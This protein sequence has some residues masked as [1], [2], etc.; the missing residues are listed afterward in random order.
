[1]DFIYSDDPDSKVKTMSGDFISYYPTQR[2]EVSVS[3]PSATVSDSLGTSISITLPATYLDR[4]DMV[5]LD[6]ITQNIG[7]R[8]LYF[9]YSIPVSEYFGLKDYLRLNGL[10]CSLETSRCE[11]ENEYTTC[12]DTASLFQNFMER[13]DYSYL[14]KECRDP[15]NM[16][17]LLVNYK[18]EL[19]AFANELVA[20]GEYQK[21]M[22]VVRKAYQIA[23][24]RL[25]EY[26]Y[27]DLSLAAV[28]YGCADGLVSQSTAC[29]QLADSICLQV[30]MRSSIVINHT[31]NT[32]KSIRTDKEERL[33]QQHIYILNSVKEILA[34]NERTDLAARASRELDRFIKILGW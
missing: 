25:S 20:N 12:N 34:S 11:T 6:I 3:S 2:V 8:P 32:P 10:V 33:L 23:P 22:S 27:F 26:G 24:E 14:V 29:N 19:A 21:A 1:L 9:C 17:R 7:S 4:S 28:V 30:A 15:E 13:F 18:I 5:L 16:K 31:L